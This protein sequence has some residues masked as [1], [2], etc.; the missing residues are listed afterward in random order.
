MFLDKP[1]ARRDS[2]SGLVPQLVM[3]TSALLASP[4]KNQLFVL[5][6]AIFLLI[7]PLAILWPSGWAWH[8]GC[9]P[10]G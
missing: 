10:K 5:A 4:L 1:E 8:A 2:H 6:G 7:Y 3:M 9:E